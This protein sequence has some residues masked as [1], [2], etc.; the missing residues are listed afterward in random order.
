MPRLK[1]HKTVTAAA[2]LTLILIAGCDANDQSP[3]TLKGEI[4]ISGDDPLPAGVSARVSLSEQGDEGAEKRIVA[5]RTLYDLGK[6]PI[7]F[8]LDVARN[9]LDPQTLYQIS[10]ELTAEDGEVLWRSSAPQRIKPLQHDQTVQLQV[11]Q[12]EPNK[13]AQF[14]KYQ[15]EDGFK[16]SAWKKRNQAVLRL[17]NRRLELDAIKKSQRYVDAHENTLKVTKHGIEVDIDGAM[18]KNCEPTEKSGAGAPVE[19]GD[20]SNSNRGRDT[21]E[22]APPSETTSNTTD[23]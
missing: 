20:L 9:L 16:L 19:A 4:E 7:A 13:Q 8:K 2:L 14:Q 15:C 10:A 22:H 23:D 21:S 6:R 1:L 18:H 17:G 11:K 3:I 5:E 12:T